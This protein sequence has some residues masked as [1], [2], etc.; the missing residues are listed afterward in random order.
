MRPRE[1]P[2]SPCVNVC[3]INPD[4]GLCRGCLRTLEEIAC[5]LEYSDDGKHDVL[6]RIA[7]RKLTFPVSNPLET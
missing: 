3:Q 1:S 6:R 2:A 5:W 4:T 7:E